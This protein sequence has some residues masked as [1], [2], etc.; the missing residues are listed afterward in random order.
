MH[1]L[2]TQAERHYAANRA[3]LERQIALSELA[4]AGTARVTQRAMTEMATIN[5]LR[6]V[7]EEVDPDGSPM[8]G[9]LAG[10]GLA[11]MA[12]VLGQE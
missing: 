7:L 12:R 1:R 2:P 9:T 11:R 10:L 6:K 5:I 8:F 4:V 3:E